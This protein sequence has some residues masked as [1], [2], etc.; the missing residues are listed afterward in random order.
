[1]GLCAALATADQARGGA[2]AGA[3]TTELR[4]SALKRGLA[5]P[6]PASFRPTAGPNGQAAGGQLEPPDVGK[7]C[8]R[9]GGRCGAAKRKV[10]AQV[11][12]LD[13]LCHQW[14]L[15]TGGALRVEG[16]VVLAAVNASGWSG[17]P[18]VCL[19]DQV[20]FANGWR[21]RS[22]RLP[23]RPKCSCDA[24]NVGC[25]ARRRRATARL[26][27]AHFNFALST[28]HKTCLAQVCSRGR[29]NAGR[30]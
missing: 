4:N 12:P 28:S 9:R 6:R 21:L 18:T 11:A 14:V 8:S 27:A 2:R 22:F 30:G 5:T 29:P 10:A 13:S 7:D 3:S 16:A 19:L 25:Q 15:A 20:A 26:V 23:L 1:M 24:A 17:A